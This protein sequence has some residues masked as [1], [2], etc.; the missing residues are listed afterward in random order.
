MWPNYLIPFTVSKPSGS[1]PANIESA[2]ARLDIHRLFSLADG[3]RPVGG[4]V[5][6]FFTGPGAVVAALV[7]ARLISPEKFA[8]DS[9]PQPR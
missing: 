2:F 4:H 5:K 9:R 3:L 7:T 1:W 6:G 8:A